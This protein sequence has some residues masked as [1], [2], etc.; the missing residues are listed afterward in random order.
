V[1]C[2]GGIGA[3]STLIAEGRSQESPALFGVSMQPGQSGDPRA[4]AHIA[5]AAI[6]APTLCRATLPDHAH[7]ELRHA[8]ATRGSRENSNGGGRERPPAWPVSWPGFASPVPAVAAYAIGG[9]TT[10]VAG[11]PSPLLTVLAGLGRNRRAGGVFTGLRR[12]IRPDISNCDWILVA[13]C[14]V[15]FHPAG[16]VLG[17]ADRIAAPASG[18]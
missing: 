7:D 5:M 1:H 17:A 3:R 13:H 16:R 9:R 6:Y 2:G 18:F 8:W 15:V 12:Y 14:R 10:I 11:G 4:G